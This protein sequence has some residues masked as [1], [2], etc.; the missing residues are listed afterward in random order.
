MLIENGSKKS[1]REV[2]VSVCRRSA[3][4]NL[5]VADNFVFSCAKG[6]VKH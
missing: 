6:A 2:S 5:S 4:K 1:E 3:G